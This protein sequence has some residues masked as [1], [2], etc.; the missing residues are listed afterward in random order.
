[1][2]YLTI[3]TYLISRDII[4]AF[5]TLHWC[6]DTPLHDILSVHIVVSWFPKYM[7]NSYF[8]ILLHYYIDSPEYLYCLSLYSYC[9]NPGLYACY[10]H[11]HVFPLHGY[12]PLLILIFPLLNTWAVDMQ[13]VESHI[14]YFHFPLY[15][16]ILST[17]L[18]S[19]YHVTCIM[20]CI[21]SCYIRS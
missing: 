6:M 4:Y 9:I 5:F 12:F 15:C 8:I 21:C 10:M 13:C 20:Y 19:C 18:R 11:I 14:Y 3:N 16:S 17:E 7:M 2:S 1:V